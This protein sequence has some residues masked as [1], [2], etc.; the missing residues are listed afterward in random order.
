[1]A[2]AHVQNTGTFAISAGTTLAQAYGSNVTSGNRLIAVCI[3][4]KTNTTT[5]ALT[6]TQGN[7]W[8]AI[9]GTLATGN[10]VDRVQVFHTSA[11]STGANT[12]T[13][14][15]NV[16][17][18][19]RVIMISEFS[20]LTG[21]LGASFVAASGT[22]ANPSSNITVGA[23]TSL[24]LGGCLTSGS[25]T[26][27][28][29]YSLLSTQTGNTSEYRLPPG[30]GSLAVAFVAASSNWA[31]GAAEFLAGAGGATVVKNLAALGVG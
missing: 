14:T 9:A 4:E 21:S 31:I 26:Q 18:D 19:V 27:G 23:A 25:C 15:T 7:T 3:W 29:S 2:W 24:I 30:T 8:S 28:A 12:V 16:S 1:M 22:S 17:T 6:D 20:G 13:M 5:C 11:G 10:T